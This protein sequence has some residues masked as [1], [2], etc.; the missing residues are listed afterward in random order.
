MLD[1]PLHRGLV[2]FFRITMGWTFLYAAVHQF[3]DPSWSAAGFLAHTKTFNSVFGVFGSPEVVPYT[4]FIVKW[5]HLLLGLSL[6]SG[7]FVRASGAVGAAVMITYLFA[8]MDFPY[9]DNKLNFLM[10]F[11]LVYAGV[12]VYLVAV[13]AGHILGLDA[14][15]EQHLP[16]L[17]HH[18]ATRTVGGHG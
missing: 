4:D 13:R 16:H 12:L 10:D 3:A 17:L 6:I 1:S 15:V 14:T 2:V 11:H 8:H 9:I 18:G 5:G 7:L